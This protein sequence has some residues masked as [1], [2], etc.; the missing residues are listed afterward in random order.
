MGVDVVDVLGVE[1]CILEGQPHRND[2]TPAVVV[3]VGQP[4]GVGRRGMAG[5][6]AEDRRSA[7]AGVLELFEHQHPAPFADH[8]PVALAVERPARPRRIVVASRHRRQQD[9]ARDAERVN[10]AVDAAGEHHVGAAAA[11]D[12]DR[13][14]DRLGARRAGR[15]AREVRA[16]RAEDARDVA[17]RRPRLLL[18]LLEPIEQSQARAA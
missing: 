18:G 1:L 2:G 5:D 7:G 4:E 10:H 9:E 8:E 16:S 17:G 14:A 15:Q 13:L 11:N 12:L 6:L 3:A